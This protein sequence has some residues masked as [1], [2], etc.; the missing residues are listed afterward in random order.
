LASTLESAAAV[1]LPATTVEVIGGEQAE[2]QRSRAA[3]PLGRTLPCAPAAGAPA[4][5]IP[6]RAAAIRVEVAAEAK[7]DELRALRG[8][9]NVPVP[10]TESGFWPLLCIVLLAVAMALAMWLMRG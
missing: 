4:V 9:D 6:A 1:V 7:E 8:P 2:A 10:P 5:R 3:D